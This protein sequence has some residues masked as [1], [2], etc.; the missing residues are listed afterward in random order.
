MEEVGY[1]K[2]SDEKVEKIANGIKINKLDVYFD[3]MCDERIKKINK[4]L[5]VEVAVDKQKELEK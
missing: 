3:K 1:H 2:I 5:D 4:E